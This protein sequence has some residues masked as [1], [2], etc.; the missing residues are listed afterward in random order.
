M[1]SLSEIDTTVKR[2]TKAI[3]FSWGIAEEVGKCIR[4]LEMFGLPGIKNLNQY[5]KVFAN[6]KFQNVSLIAKSNISKVSYCPIISGV[7]FLDQ[8]HTLQ[9][10]EEI[11]FENFGFPILFIPFLSRSSEIIGKRIFLKIDDKEFL[12][13][14]NQ[15][16]FSNYFNKNVIENANIIKISF[17]ENKD[18]F[19]DQDWQDLYKLSEQTFVEETDELK[20]KAAGAGLTDND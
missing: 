4:T 5:Y 6:K 7:N 16:I 11:E 1:I 18:S 13:N 19:S 3:G 15:S 12:L 2:A 17:I 14:F 20:Q 10:L 9:N 8:I